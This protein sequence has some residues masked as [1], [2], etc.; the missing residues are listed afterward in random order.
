MAE[1][2]SILVVED[3]LLIAQQLV[4]CLE[5]A[6]YHVVGTAVSVAEALE[7]LSQQR[8]DLVLLDIHLEGS[9]DGIDLAN[10][11]RT[12]FQLPFVYITSNTDARTLARVKLTQ[13]AGFIVKPFQPQDLEPSIEIA[14]YNSIQ[15]EQA[16]SQPTTESFFVKDRH[17]MQRVFYGDIHYAEAADNYTIL[18]TPR[19]KFMLSQTLK[20]IE[21]KLRPHGFL[22]IHRSYVVNVSKIDCVRPT[23]VLVGEK[24]LATSSTARSSLLK[25]IH[26][27]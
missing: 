14:L 4:F 26:T 3:E 19:K 6:G 18:H 8:P 20:S 21:Q 13:P 17:E 15:R 27:L 11:L 1:Q 22:R 23:E 5:D 16:P 2:K 10:E 24:A 25:F 9:L 7:L 12:R